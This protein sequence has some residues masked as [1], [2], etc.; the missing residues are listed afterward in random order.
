VQARSSRYASRAMRRRHVGFV[1]V[2]EEGP[3]S[4]TCHSL[5]SIWLTRSPQRRVRGFANNCAIWSI[6]FPENSFVA[7]TG[8][9]LF[10]TSRGT[11]CAT[12]T[13]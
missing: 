9:M 1:Q 5:G 4:L 12:K 8:K 2:G 7:L 3:K 10:A 13:L 11:G 6:A